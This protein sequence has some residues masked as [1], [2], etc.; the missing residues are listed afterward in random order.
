MFL[1]CTKSK[2][3]HL[4]KFGWWKHRRET[5]EGGLYCGSLA[6]E[7]HVHHFKGKEGASRIPLCLLELLKQMH[8]LSECRSVNL[9]GI[10]T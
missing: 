1:A 4:L 10:F 7:F 6:G 5:G 2:V 9:I 8:T 3:E